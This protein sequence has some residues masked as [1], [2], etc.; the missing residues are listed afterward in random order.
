[1]IDH[2]L[3]VRRDGKGSIGGAVGAAG[4]ERSGR[5]AGLTTFSVEEGG[6]TGL[7]EGES[8]DGADMAWR[9]AMDRQRLGPRLKIGT[10]QVLR[11]RDEGREQERERERE[12]ERRTTDDSLVTRHHTYIDTLVNTYIVPLLQ[13][14][15][16]PSRKTAAHLHLPVDYGHS[17]AQLEPV[18]Y[19]PE[20][21]MESR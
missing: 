2:W 20:R 11:T 3:Y 5:M 14:S 4:T 8:E 17:M 19:S 21:D 15:P 18:P 12:R 9:L 13:L 16:R 6:R 10:D 7:G 1:M